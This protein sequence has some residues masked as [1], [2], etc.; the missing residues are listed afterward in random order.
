MVEHHR[1]RREA[2]A[3]DILAAANFEVDGKRWQRR[4]ALLGQRAA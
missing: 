1:L 2:D 4:R 3:T